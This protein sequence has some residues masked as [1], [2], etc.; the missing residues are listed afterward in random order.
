[1]EQQSTVMEPIYPTLILVFKFIPENG[2]GGLV[3]WVLYLCVA[4]GKVHQLLLA[5][6]EALMHPVAL[7]YCDVLGSGLWPSSDCCCSSM[8][9]GNSGKIHEW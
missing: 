2:F 5:A 1:M 9:V 6:A 7:M 3:Y 8:G 4:W